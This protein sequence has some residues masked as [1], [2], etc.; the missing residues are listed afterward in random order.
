[1]VT[2]VGKPHPRNT[3][4]RNARANAPMPGLW[5][6]RGPATLS[7]AIRCSAS[8]R[9]TLGRIGRSE[10]GFFAPESIDL[11]ARLRYKNDT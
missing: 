6:S 1:M 7:T 2:R 11:F 10:F 9:R 8:Q 4:S 3:S 5:L